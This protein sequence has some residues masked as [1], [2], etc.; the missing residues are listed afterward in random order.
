M[1]LCENPIIYYVFSTSKTFIFIESNENLIIYYVLEPPKNAI[2]Y[3]FEAP[4][5]FQE[6]RQP[7]AGPD[8]W[9]LPP[10]DSLLLRITMANAT[11]IA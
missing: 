11:S 7:S 4:K 6:I 2:Y 3:V 9:P 5:E 1:P 8:I 10:S